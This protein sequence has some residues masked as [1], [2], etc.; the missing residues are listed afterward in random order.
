MD[1]EKYQKLEKK[2]KRQSF[3]NSYK[4]INVWAFIF[5]IFGNFASVFF[6]YF[7]L[8][9]L[10]KDSMHGVESVWIISLISIVFL[11]MF[12][13]LKRYVFNKF[14]LEHIRSNF[15]FMKKEVLIL[16]L[17]SLLMVSGSFYLSL[18]GAQKFTDKAESIEQTTED[19][20][21]TYQDSLNL[22][23]AEQNK[24]FEDKNLALK[25]ENKLLTDQNIQLNSEAE[26]ATSNSIKRSK[27]K[28]IEQNNERI[29]KNNEKIDANDIIIQASLKE[30]NDK[31]MVKKTELESEALVLNEK[32]DNNGVKFL[33]L[34][35]FIELIILVGI[36]FN[37]FYDYKSFREYEETMKADPNF[38]KWVNYDRLLE[39]I[40][41]SGSNVVRVGDTV[42]PVN[43]LIDLARINNF[44]KLDKNVINDGFKVLNHLGIVTTRGSKRIVEVDFEVAKEV[45][46]QYFN[47]V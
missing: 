28:L 2:I 21:L 3:S 29:G 10:L 36:Y 35:T 24:Q 41:N 11:S 38:S 16:T 25:D 37:S 19:L 1:F 8:F 5:S 31:L 17:F 15:K 9:S 22:M 27:Y 18:N 20:Y 40:Y 34:S 23:Y 33:I 12:E 13:M 42:S 47:I 7:L 30:R 44:L 4:S 32:G 45:L 14:S 26:N 6:A 43:K 46:K 39:L